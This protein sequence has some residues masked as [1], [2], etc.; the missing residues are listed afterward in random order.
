LLFQNASTAD[1]IT[2]YDSTLTGGVH[3][4]GSESVYAYGIHGERYGR[5]QQGDLVIL[6]ASGNQ[7]FIPRFNFSTDGTNRTAGLYVIDVHYEIRSGNIW[8]T[9]FEAAA[10][11]LQSLKKIGAALHGW[12]LHGTDPLV[13]DLDGNGIPLTDGRAPASSSTSTQP[14]C[15]AGGLGRRQRRHPGSRPQRQRQD[16]QRHRGVSA[17]PRP[18]ALRNWRRSTATMTARSTPSDNGLADLNGDGIVDA[19]DSFDSLKVW[20]DANQDGV[21]DAGELHALSDYDIVSIAVGSTPS[22]IT[23]SGNDIVATG[24]FQRA[25]GTTGMVGEVQLDTDNHN[26]R[27][28]GDSSVS[29][30]AASRPDLKGFG[31]LTDLH[32]AMTLDPGLIGVVDAASPG[33]NSLSLASLRAAVQPLLGA[34]GAAVPI[35]A[36]T[37]GAEPTEDFNFVGTTTVKGAIVHDYL[38]EKQD[39][40]GTYYAYAQRPAGL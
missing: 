22:T 38:I 35:P 19:S 11:M 36:G 25:D 2:Y 31:T 20:V 17:A 39:N 1:H 23:D 3:W 37:P 7:T 32:V 13:L 26:T 34:W 21:T 16:R 33:L 40:L 27:W 6:D 15:H 10:I 5:N 9:G 14:V 24:T 12:Q 8:T 29:A 18:R 28:T 4:G 30:A